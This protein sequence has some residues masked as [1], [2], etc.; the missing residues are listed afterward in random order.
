V[1]AAT[2]PLPFNL[3]AADQG[4]VK[5]ADAS[6]YV[7]HYQNT[8]L[9]VQGKWAVENADVVVRFLRGLIGST[10][11]ILSNREEFAVYAMKKLKM[12]RDYAIAGWDTYAGKKIWPIDGSPTREGLETVIRHQVRLGFLPDG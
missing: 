2:L 8:T 7:R 11:W 3:I 10:K 6:D 1:D 9:L 12:K 4:A 5:L